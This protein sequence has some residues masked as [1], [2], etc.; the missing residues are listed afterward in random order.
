MNS[1]AK[2]QSILSNKY[3]RLV[4]AALV[5]FV[6]VWLFLPKAGVIRTIPFLVFCAAGAN[7]LCRDRRIIVGLAAV[8]TLFLYC[9]DGNALSKAIFFTFAAAVL[10]YVGTFVCR[11]TQVCFTAKKAGTARKALVFGIA[12]IVVGIALYVSVCGNIFSAISNNSANSKY[13]KENYD[14]KVNKL[15]TYYAFPELEYRTVINF[16]DDGIFV[17]EDDDVYISRKG[18]SITDG[19]RDYAE[20][21]MLVSSSNL[22]KYAIGNATDYFEI[23]DADIDFDDGEVLTLDAEGKTYFDRT[24]YVVA[25]YALVDDEDAFAKICRDCFMTLQVTS[26]FTYKSITFVAGDA[27]KM[28][29]TLTVTPESTSDNLASEVKPFDESALEGFDATEDS[30]LSYWGEK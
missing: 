14:G 6:G 9:A 21:K 18:E 26:N 13:I 1:K 15:Y 10:S 22:L 30:I 3:I 25:L 2:K 24:E 5:I 11:M 16:N 12:A 8:M 7:I 28:K 27:K 29:Y 20:D 17:G 23:S 19:F 4:L